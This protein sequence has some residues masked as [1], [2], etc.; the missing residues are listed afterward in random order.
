MTAAPE[1][2]ASPTRSGPSLATRLMIAQAVVLVVGIGAAALVASLV[3]PPLFHQHLL[4]AGHNPSPMELAHTEE[5]Y[6]SANAAS[7]TVALLI[8]L[9]CAI[10]VTWYA[11][12][13]ITRPLLALAGVAEELSA[14]DYGVRA[15]Q[16]G[17]GPEL[18]KLAAT[19]NDVA[20]RLQTTEDTRRRLLSDLA[21]EMRT[22]L[23]TIRARLEGLED[24]VISWTPETAQV[25]REQAG[26]L[27]RLADDLSEVSRAEE[28]RLDLHPA[29]TEVAALIRSAA[30]AWS[31]AY[32]DRGVR[33]VD[34]TARPGPGEVPSGLVVEVDR[35]RIQQV[36]ANLLANAL[37]HTPTGGAVSIGAARVGSA[38]R[39]EVADTGDGID[40]AQLPHVFER[41]YRGDTARAHD[42][43]GSGI[44]LTIAR[45]IA[46]AHGGHLEGLSAGAGEG[47]AF[48]LTLPL[49][50]P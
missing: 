44:G 24:E 29:P 38:V 9:V 20:T 33:L 35:D 48:V 10:A 31:E 30:Q 41:F 49:A 50:R 34:P 3:G 23:A 5:A 27:E 4:E 37:R 1:R 25:L 32:R 42:L 39:I 13:R 12:R 7:L 46:L 16:T 47:A 40:P 28:N 11:A 22:P 15:P 43:G 45:S 17:G 6:A 26:R 21:H 8:A 14:G 36:L 19:F 2:P 18:D